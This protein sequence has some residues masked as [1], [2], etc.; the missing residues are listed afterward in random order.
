VLQPEQRVVLR[1]IDWEGYET[2]LKVIGDQAAVRLAYDGGDLELM[3]PSTDHDGYKTLIGRMIEVLTMELDIPCE[4]LGSSTWKKTLADKGIEPDE[5]YYIASSARVAGRF[6]IDL[7]VDPAP[8]L[9]IEI[10]ISRSALD[11]M[12]IYAALGVSEVWRFDGETLTVEV[13]Q[14]DG[15]YSAQATSP[16]LPFLPLDRLVDWIYEADGVSQTTWIRR[17]RDWVLAEFGPRND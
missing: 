12:G 16:S 1:G 13:L 9:A 6:D 15:T 4:G 8:D 10:E 7:N 14:A 5:C 2:I 17:F 3:S 11:R